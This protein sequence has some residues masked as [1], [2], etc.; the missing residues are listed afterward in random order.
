ML[1][2]LKAVYSNVFVSSPRI[3]QREGSPREPLYFDARQTFRLRQN[4]G[5]RKPIFGDYLSRMLRTPI[6]NALVFSFLMTSFAAGVAWFL[7]P[8]P[9]ARDIFEFRRK[10]PGMQRHQAASLSTPS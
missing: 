3:E 5:L 2:R 9:L 4:A 8:A 6:S 7:T 10:D 1:G